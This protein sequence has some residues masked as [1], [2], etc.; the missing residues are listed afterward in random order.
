[1][2]CYRSLL[3][4]ASAVGIILAGLGMMVARPARDEPPLF[5]TFI[6]I[7]TAPKAVALLGDLREEFQNRS[8]RWGRSAARLWY[9]VEV[10]CLLTSFV[11]SVPLRIVTAIAVDIARLLNMAKL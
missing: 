5:A 9:W 7:A 6:A 4:I 1:M 2:G 11:S 10:A 3:G 8:R